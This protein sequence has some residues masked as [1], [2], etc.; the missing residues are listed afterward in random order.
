MVRGSYTRRACNYCR[1]RKSKCDGVQPRCGTC[2]ASA[3]ECS[4]GPEIA[5]RTVNK[6]HVDALKAWIRQLKKRADAQQAHIEALQATGRGGDINALQGHLRS[7]EHDAE[8]Y[9]DRSSPAS[10]G[11]LVKAEEPEDVDI[12]HL[13]APTMHFRFDE[14]RLELYGPTSIFRL[15]P[16]HHQPSTTSRY[17]D[18]RV[19]DR[20]AQSYQLLPHDCASLPS[21][22]WN[23]HLPSDSPLTRPEHD[24][25]LEIMFTFFTSWCLRVIPDLFLLDMHRSLSV[26]RTQPTF[27]T[28]HYSPML[29]NA[30]IAVAT[31]FSDDPRVKDPDVRRRYAD[32][33]RD[34]L[35][36]EC[37]RPKLSAVIGSSILADYH[38]SQGNPTLGHMYFGISARL[39]QALGLGLDCSPWVSAGLISE[40][41]ML[42]R[43][44]VF[45]ATFCQDTTWSLYVGRDF[46]VS[47]SSDI[48]R[49]PVPSFDIETSLSGERKGSN[50]LSS[51]FFSTSE[52]LQIAR[53]ITDVVSN[54]SRLGVRREANNSVVARMDLKLSTWKQKLSPE[55]YLPQSG[56]TTPMPHQLMLHMTYDWL[57]IV[58]HRPFYR[59]RST[60]GKDGADEIH[61][62]SCND[63]AMDIM[64]LAGSW[65][66]LY[67]LRYVPIAFIQ[68]VF[69]AG[70]IFILSAVQAIARS[71]IAQDHFTAACDNAQLA[72][73]YLQEVGESFE[74]ARGVAGILR[75]LLEHQVNSRLTRRCSPDAHLDARNMPELPSPSSDDG[76]CS[77]RSLPSISATGSAPG[78]GED[79]WPNT[80]AS[81]ASGSSQGTLRRLEYGFE[82]DVDWLSPT[83]PVH[84]PPNHH[85]RF[86]AGVERHSGQL[87][88]AAMDMG[89]GM[90]LGDPHSPIAVDPA[91]ANYMPYRQQWSGT[92]GYATVSG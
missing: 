62:Q 63:A 53:D 35:E 90:Q 58:L 27:I 1:K 23:R 92:V 37:E 69:A 7:N 32:R 9:D 76:S 66:T 54:F 21:I 16:H 18:A 28:A 60:S 17:E 79:S 45:W 38:S 11:T 51:T 2:I 52:L 91:Q 71:H 78:Y 22:D 56:D 15:V 59:R 20:N 80:D 6:Q 67:T 4:W 12:E 33:A 70:T 44:W 36:F 82:S 30:L 42:D 55:L 72:I 73:Q 25:L 87:D 88:Y 57:V 40:S 13:I 61:I 3:D 41:G 86:G 89:S 19:V 46:C 10:D 68:V 81:D 43:N 75:N 24:K 8:H 34:C 50:F 64:D 48:H 39:S 85:Q 83:E 74:C 14:G 47:S 29:H 5:K 84:A 31:A 26:S 49:I 77:W 65:R